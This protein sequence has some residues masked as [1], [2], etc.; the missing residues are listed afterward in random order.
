M[1]E[2]LVGQERL[3]TE[4][5]DRERHQAGQL[6]EDQLLE[7]DR[8]LEP[9]VSEPG[10]LQDADERE[11]DEQNNLENRQRRQL[12]GKRNAVRHRLGVPQLIALEAAVLPDELAGVDRRQHDEEQLSNTPRHQVSDR[13][14]RHIPR[15]GPTPRADE[16]QPD[17]A[18]DH[19]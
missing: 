1:T 6:Q 8:Q 4:S 14:H 11:R 18:D 13:Q 9:V 5:H 17:A 2:E 7:V 16:V 19:R 10:L 15:E 12:T 3:Q